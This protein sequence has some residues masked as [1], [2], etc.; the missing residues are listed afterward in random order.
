MRDAAHQSLLQVQ[1]LRE[2]H[3]TDKNKNYKILKKSY[4]LRD[5]NVFRILHPS[6]TLVPRRIY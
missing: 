1:I 3:T 5:T 6:L 4:V 2:K